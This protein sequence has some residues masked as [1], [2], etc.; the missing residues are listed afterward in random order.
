MSDS[1]SD[2]EPEIVTAAEGRRDALELMKAEKKSRLSKLSE[3]KAKR[4]K[5]NELFVEQSKKKLTDTKKEDD[6]FIP[7]PTEVLDAVD[8]DSKSSAVDS[9][10]TSEGTQGLKLKK[11]EGVHISFDKQLDMI[12]KNKLAVTLNEK[13]SKSVL[14]FKQRAFN[15][16]KRKQIRAV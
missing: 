4:R 15:R 11:R 2:S 7:L 10:K 13:V 14:D 8:D 9:M 3:E 16:V 5:R 1:S 12:E 6:D